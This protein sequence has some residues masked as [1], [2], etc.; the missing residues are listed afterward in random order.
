MATKLTKQDASGTT[1]KTNLMS[2]ST[3]IHLRDSSLLDSSDLLALRSTSQHFMEV[4]KFELTRAS[5]LTSNRKSDS[6]VPKK[7]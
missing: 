5:R 6:L 1:A 2:L 3:E 4:M 7:Q